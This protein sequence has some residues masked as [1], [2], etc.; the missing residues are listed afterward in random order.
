MYSY[1][2]RERVGDGADVLVLRRVVAVLHRRGDDARRR[3]G[4]ERLRERARRPPSAHSRLE[5]GAVAV[6]HRRRS[7]PGAAIR[8]TLIRA[9]RGSISSMKSG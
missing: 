5:L 9:N 2:V 1:S 8:L 6:G 7:P 4:H 3:R